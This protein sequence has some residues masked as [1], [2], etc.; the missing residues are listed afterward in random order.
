MSSDPTILYLYCFQL[1]CSH[2]SHCFFV[3]F[4]FKISDLHSEKSLCMCSC[5]ARRY[6]INGN[7]I[8][9]GLDTLMSIVNIVK[10]TSLGG[11]SW[12]LPA[13]I[14]MITINPIYHILIKARLLTWQILNR[15]RKARK[16]LNISERTNWRLNG[17]AMNA[18]HNIAKARVV[19][20]K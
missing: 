18:Q 12:R 8:S 17:C 9:D 19:N 11:L 10:T 7:I 1:V 14:R 20:R 16:N 15:T 5:R 3:V 4:C 13:Q 6:A 2:F